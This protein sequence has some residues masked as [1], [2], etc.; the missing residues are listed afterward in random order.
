M[1]E[2]PRGSREPAAPRHAPVK[3]T[4]VL[5][6]FVKLCLYARSVSL[7]CMQYSAMENDRKKSAMYPFQLHSTSSLFCLSS[8]ISKILRRVL[9]T[10]SHPSLYL[11][12]SKLLY[13]VS[14]RCDRSLM[15]LNDLPKAGVTSSS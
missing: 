10:P 1:S 9:Q 7:V 2:T 11:Q 8:H 13:P 4:R 3:R 15:K 14:R 6:L 12:T 5:A